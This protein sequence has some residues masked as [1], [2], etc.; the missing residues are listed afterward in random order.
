MRR[1]VQHTEQ[2][3]LAEDAH[4]ARHLWVCLQLVLLVD[5]PDNFVNHEFL[6]EHLLVGLLLPPLL[7]FELLLQVQVVLRLLPVPLVLLDALFLQ[8]S[9]VLLHHGPGYLGITLLAWKQN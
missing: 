3:V 9:L 5:L 2:L 7:L 4:W 6:F 8:E 1:A